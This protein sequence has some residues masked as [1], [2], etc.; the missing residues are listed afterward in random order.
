MRA[1]TC[2][3]C[4][5]VTQTLTHTHT[6]AYTHTHT[7]RIKDNNCIRIYCQTYLQPSQCATKKK[8]KQTEKVTKRSICR[9][10]APYSA[11]RESSSRCY[12]GTERHLSRRVC[13]CCRREIVF[14][15]AITIYL[16]KVV[17]YFHSVDHLYDCCNGEAFV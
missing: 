16:Y 17:V 3:R 11:S 10:D 7:H 1:R 6:L 8:K 12:N 13:L 2:C 5:R 9:D 14:L 15:L 4:A